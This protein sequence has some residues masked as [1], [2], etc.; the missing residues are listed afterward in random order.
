MEA[1]FKSHPHPIPKKG[2]YSSVKRDFTM[3]DEQMTQGNQMNFTFQVKQLHN[4]L[5]C[6]SVFPYKYERAVSCLNKIH[7]EVYWRSISVHC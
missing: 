7:K 1:I 4:W 5:L 3:S 2:I 6:P